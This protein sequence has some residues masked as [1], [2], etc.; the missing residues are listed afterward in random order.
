MIRGS[1]PTFEFL[2][3]A[4]AE[5]FS[6]IDLAF[7]QKELVLLNFPKEFLS[8]KDNT[9][10]ITL[11]EQETL[12]FE[13]NIPAEIQIRL[14]KPDGTVLMSEIRRFHVGRSYKSPE[15]I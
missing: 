2:L 14:K 3:P 4:Y 5:S 13:E 6:E 8:L 7:M 15:I 10:S 11:T 1:T 9:A 12:C